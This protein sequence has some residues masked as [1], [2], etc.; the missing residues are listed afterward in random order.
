M[1]ILVRYL[2]FEQLADIL[3]A[4][5]KLAR[6]N[7]EADLVCQ[8]L[9]QKA[10]ELQNGFA[11]GLFGLLRPFALKK[12]HAQPVDARAELFIIDG[13]QQIIGDLELERLAAVGKIVVAR[14][15]DKGRARFR[16]RDSSMTLSPLMV[17][18]L[19]SMM[20]M[21]GLSASICESACTPSAASPTTSQPC[22]PQSNSRLKPSRIIISSSTSRTFK[23]FMRPPPDREA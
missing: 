16:I 8:M 5:V 21:S 4:Q 7:V 13:L 12:R 23:R 1:R 2:A 17:G 15:D 14:D 22:E 9:L 19:M 10:R 11:L 6:E 3:R 18:M 20:T